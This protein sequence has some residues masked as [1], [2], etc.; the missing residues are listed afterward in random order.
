MTTFVTLLLAA[1]G[2]LCL[3]IPLTAV[4]VVYRDELAP[5]W[6]AVRRALAFDPRHPALHHTAAR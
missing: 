3:G 5:V 4:A 6:N 2:V 1:L